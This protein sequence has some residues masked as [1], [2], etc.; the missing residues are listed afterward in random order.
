MKISYDVILPILVWLAFVFLIVFFGVLY[1]WAK[2]RKGAALAVGL[3]IQM[4]LPD[5][6]VQHTIECVVELKE[7]TREKQSDKRLRA[8]DS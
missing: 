7:Q 4:F 6:K 5:P 2:K 8:K 3:L 1:R